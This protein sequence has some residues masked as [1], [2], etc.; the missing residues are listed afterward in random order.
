MRYHSYSSFAPSLLPSSRNASLLI[1]FARILFSFEDN[2][3]RAIVRRVRRGRPF[4][5]EKASWLMEQCISLVNSVGGTADTLFQ[6]QLVSE[7]DGGFDVICLHCEMLCMFFGLKENDWVV[8]ITI[9]QKEESLV[10]VL[11]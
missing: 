2:S 9:V 10:V 11:L 7:C 1:Y 4:D 6:L 5:G 3:V 8:T